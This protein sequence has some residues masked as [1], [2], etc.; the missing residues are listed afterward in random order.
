M[1]CFYA[2]YIKD[3]VSNDM[4]KSYSSHVG[5]SVWNRLCMED[6]DFDFWMKFGYVC[7]TLNALKSVSRV[8]VNSKCLINRDTVLCYRWKP[9]EGSQLGRWFR[10]GNFSLVRLKRRSKI[11]VRAIGN[12][13]TVWPGNW[14]YQMDPWY[15][16]H[17]VLLILFVHLMSPEGNKVNS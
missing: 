7:D 17:H 14:K 16:H 3:W 6:Q 4:I 9:M 8:Q 11:G 1:I 5:V 13:W 2:K 10:W 12:P 15:L